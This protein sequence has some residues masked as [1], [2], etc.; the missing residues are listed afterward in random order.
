MIPLHSVGV[1]R[2]VRRLTAR[3]TITDRERLAI[4]ALTG[5]VVTMRAHLDFVQSGECVDHS[6]LIVEGI[7]GRYAESPNGHRQITSVYIPGDMAD[8]PS[9]VSPRSAWG[10]STLTRST[11]L[12]IPHTQVRQL[13]AAHP[14]VAEAFWRDC[15]ADGSIFSEWV[16]NV[17]R[18]DALS[19]IAHLLCELA[20]R[21][22]QAGI[23]D[24]QSYPLK[25]TQATLADAT[26]LTGVHV[27]RTLRQLKELLIVMFDAGTVTIQNW[28]ELVGIADFDRGYLLFGG[29]APRI[30]QLSEIIL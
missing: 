19:R 1:P 8:L 30:T 29:P 26:G 16:M 4:L 15:V 22:E 17:G 28:G 24:Q 25:I 9:V 23:G 13:A 20:I 27:N 5:E 18:R 2:F 3:S 7:A 14:G 11:I 21:S 10:L 6:C 12:R